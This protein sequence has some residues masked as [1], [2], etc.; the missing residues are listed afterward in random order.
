[1]FY[2]LDYVIANLRSYI[3]IGASM[4]ADSVNKF[5]KTW[6]TISLTEEN[7]MYAYKVLFDSV[8]AWVRFPIPR[9][10]R[11]HRLIFFNPQEFI[12]DFICFITV[13][14]WVFWA[15]EC[16]FMQII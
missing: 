14:V 5:F 13:L 7:G 2:K 1:V 11:E 12:E 9:Y 10:T 6:V 8:E 15:G 4:F 16:V 3:E